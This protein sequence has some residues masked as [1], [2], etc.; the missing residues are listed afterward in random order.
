MNRQIRRGSLLLC[1][2]LVSSPAAG[3]EAD[4]DALKALHARVIRAHLESNVELIVEDD[5]NDYVVANRGEITRPTVDD[6]R[7]RLGPFLRSVRFAEYKDLVPPIVAVSEDGTLGWVVVQ[8]Q[9]RGSRKTDAGAEEPVEYVSAW[10]EMYRKLDG[11][12]RRVGNVSNF[13]E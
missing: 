5:A 2:L 3:A 12:W 1:A 7:K 9:A 10:I 6:R 8:I 13:K 11:R 4:A